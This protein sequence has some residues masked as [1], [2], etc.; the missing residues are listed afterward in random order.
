MMATEL[1]AFLEYTGMDPFNTPEKSTFFSL[2]SCSPTVFIDALNIFHMLA[3]I[4]GE[5]QKSRGAKVR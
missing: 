5:S 1:N 4:L 3:L 2:A